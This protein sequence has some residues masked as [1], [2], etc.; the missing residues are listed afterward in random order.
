MG[1]QPELETDELRKLR[2][3]SQVA[4]KLMLAH[5]QQD[6]G[7]IVTEYIDSSF[8]VGAGYWKF[9]KECRVLYPVAQSGRAKA[10]VGDQPTFSADGGSIAWQCFSQNTLE[11]VEDVHARKKIYDSESSF[12]SEIFIPIAS[13][14][15]V[16]LG[17]EESAAFTERDMR[18]IQLLQ[19]ILIGAVQRLLREKSFRISQDI[20]ERV[21]RHD[22][23]NQMNVIR[24][25]AEIVQERSS[26]ETVQSQTQRIIDASE[27]LCDISKDI[28]VMQDVIQSPNENTQVNLSS[29]VKELIAEI[30]AEHK[31]DISSELPDKAV[32]TSHREVKTAIEELILNAIEHNDN[33]MPTVT[34]AIEK[35]ERFVSLIIED[36]GPGIPDTEI[37]VI[38]QTRETKLKHGSGIGLWLADRIAY[39]SGGTLMLNNENGT[40]VEVVLPR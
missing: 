5:D 35:H 4:E 25:Y 20:Y 16:I 30:A 2:D 12:Q 15:L 26:N 39:H 13:H 7:G 17:G 40:R 21:F 19:N 18:I 8:G 28:S 3:L 10:L 33:R 31:C 37:E 36:E 27:S 23:R 6:I 32:V 9:D 11:Y 24:S 34:V 1:D 22:I 38:R 29:L 14:G